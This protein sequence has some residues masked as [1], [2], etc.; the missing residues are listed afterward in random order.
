MPAL[1]LQ[2]QLKIAALSAD[3][4]RRAIIASLLSSPLLNWRYGVVAPDQVLIV[5]GDLRN[6]DPSFWAELSEGYFGLA[7]VMA[8]L[9]GG[10]PFRV[11]P[12]SPAWERELYGFGWLRHLAA[13]DEPAAFE[14]GR[15][16]ALE[17]IALDE[18][19]GL[20]WEP[21]ILARRIVSWLSHT[22][23]LLDGADP[24]TYATI[25]RSLGRQVMRLAG[26]WRMAP[27]GYP[28]LFC[29]TALV[30]ADLA[31]VGHDKQL[32]KALQQLAPELERQFL[33]GGAHASRN[34]EVLVEL[35]LDFLP[36]SKCF[37]SRGREPTPI[38]AETIRKAIVHL[39]KMRLGNGMLA[40]FNGV[41]VPQPAKLA[42]V[43]PYGDADDRD[44]KH[45]K[46]S[47]YV[48]LERGTS[49]VII[50]AGPPPPMAFAAEASAGCLS[51]EM[52]SG[53]QLVFV[54]GGMPGPASRDWEPRARATA[55]HNTLCLGEKSSSRLLR[56]SQLQALV[57]GMPIRNPA[58]V[59]CQISEGNGAAV[60]EA[61]H[62]GYLKRFRLV[63]WRAISLA[64]SG[65][66][67]AG[68]D[69]LARPHQ[70][71]R[72]AEAI[73][74]AIHFHMH[75]DVH[76]TLTPGAAGARDIRLRLSNG[77]AWVFA[78]EGAETH[79]EES[80]FFA[81]NGG[82]RQTLQ[83]VLRGRTAGEYEVRWWLR[84]IAHASD[85]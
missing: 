64:S 42:T 30:Q 31:V 21:E 47:G 9:K 62:D 46:T 84:R 63:H 58:T 1:T 69:R 6:A 66:E 79:I 32:R 72:F 52:S 67:L 50:D 45:E 48:R 17:W 51:F 40:R 70:R 80:V 15:K 29:L 38:L 11:R 85:A 81:D 82:P 19:K 14:R 55:S 18:G 10:S 37:K 20:A 76:C 4:S 68:V 83:I 23:V 28:R 33:P 49:I 26:T 60:V 57:G 5:P 35:L 44:L 34:A 78:A 61:S 77:E 71:A 43:L 24:Q 59:T 12:P 16:L 56:S 25:T 75:P 8:D 41:G 13:V 27:D 74:F 22:L 54:N 3:R 53:E 65:G 73:P 36:L 39:R 7:G 2:D